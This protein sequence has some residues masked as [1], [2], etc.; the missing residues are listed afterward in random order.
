MSIDSKTVDKLASQASAGGGLVSPLTAGDVLATDPG[1]LDINTLGASEIDVLDPK[2]EPQPQGVEVAGPFTRGLGR[3]LS[4]KND[5]FNN[6][7]DKLQILK[8]GGTLDVLNEAEESKAVE[9]VTNNVLGVISEQTEPALAVQPRVQTVLPGEQEQGDMLGGLVSREDEF[10]DFDEASTVAYNAFSRGSVIRVDGSEVPTVLGELETPAQ[11]TNDG[12]LSDFRAVGGS[13]DA[14]IPD[15]GTILSSIEAISKTYAGQITD[16]KRGEIT[17]EATRQMADLLGVDP[18]RVAKIILARQTGG[19]LIDREG[20]A[21]LAETMLASRDLLVSELK[22]LDGLAKTAAT[23]GDRDALMF[24]AQLEL[25]ANLQMQI[26]GA[27]TE[28]ARALSSFRVPARDG[29]AAPDMRNQDLT[30]LLG[31]YGGTEDIRTMAAMYMQQ[32]DNVAAK[33]AI[34]RKGSKT[35]KVTDAFYE[36]WINI[37]L[38]NPITHTKNI[39][40][41]F[42]TTFAHVPETYA[43]AAIGAARRAKG[44]E[45]GVYFGQANAQLFAAS[46]AMR[47]AFGAAGKA[48]VTGER[49]MPGTKI[50]G[51]KGRRAVNAFSSDGMAEGK[52][53]TTVDILG[54]I[55]T[56]G[57][58]PTRALEFED[59]FFK[60]IAHRMSLYEQAYSTGIAKGFRQDQLS[61]HIAEYMFNPPSEGLK[62]ADGHAKYVTLQN[63]LDPTGKAIQNL[64]DR[65]PGLRYFAPFLKTPYNAFKYAF[66]DRG[67]IGAFYGETRAAVSRSK[68][69]GASQTDKAA[70][71]MAMARLVM[72]NATAFTMIGLVAEG[73][74]T[75]A[76][77]AE[78]G[79][80]ENLRAQGWR[81]YSIKLPGSNPPEYVSYMGLEP[82]ASI[83]MLGSD[84]GEVLLNGSLSQ[85]DGGE[86]AAGIAASFAHQ[87]T[88]K[89]FMSG[90]NNLIATLNDPTRN[91]KGTAQ[92][93]LASLVPR[94]VAQSE[95]SG[96]LGADLGGAAISEALQLERGGFADVMLQG[97]P[98]IRAT[99]TTLDKFKAQLPGWSSTLPPKLNMYGQVQM[100]DGSLG[101]DVVSPFYSATRGPNP[102]AT[103]QGFAQ[104]V[105]DVAAELTTIQYSPS[106][107]GNMAIS[108]KMGGAIKGVEL[109]P[110]EEYLYHAYAGKRTVEFL[111][112][113][114]KSSVYKNFKKQA[115]G[116]KEN[117]PGV[118]NAVQNAVMPDTYGKQMVVVNELAQEQA[119]MV[120]RRALQA[121]RNVAFQ[122]LLKDREVGRDV[123][124]RIKQFAKDAAGQMKAIR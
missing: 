11:L 123:K 20:G 113:A 32:G 79:L 72:G 55:M 87:L 122:D 64:R 30:S 25:V 96:I 1:Q 120:L 116:K 45:G 38:S 105:V 117:A 31:D 19:V 74:I 99:R 62:I 95:R 107:L 23:G 98:I 69:P 6:A 12:L 2:I 44:G 54:H 26:K 18:S 70:G 114:I 90:F 34:V 119:Q 68:L 121:A 60:V 103:D 65:M 124:S 17:L 10:A 46:M 35:K 109:K 89:T 115:L 111:E 41:A 7:A 75:G 53:A 67:P 29:Q 22:K 91:A 100:L 77:P 94:V 57:R 33:A 104:R 97:D 9:G 27:Q 92:S 93:L 8:D 14:K 81:P 101:P 83:L 21:G 85:A 88:D 16:E 118:I 13:G 73:S 49:V 39:V 42:I 78:P 76:G 112:K 37:L 36:A 4:P 50:E 43:A 58:V 52:F 51:G 47:E 82:F 59:T 15:E 71:D 61:T 3:A 48:F 110:Q 106:R 5:V 40:G 24:R 66:I 56:L 80:R 63:D 86:I 102:Q 108:D 84:A 28:I